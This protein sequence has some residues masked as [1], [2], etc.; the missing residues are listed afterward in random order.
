MRNPFMALTDWSVDRPKQAFAAV[1]LAMFTLAAGGMHLQ[2]DNSEDGFFPDDPRVDLLN[3]I[4]SEYR[5]NL[6]FIRFIDEIEGEALLEA[7]TWEQLAV[8]EAM[9]LND[10]NLEPYHYP[11]F[12]TQAN[13][14]PA[15]Q[16]MQ[17]M[18]LQDEDT[19]T[20]WLAGLQKA[21]VEVL[22]AN[23][24]ANLS[25]ALA[26]L[27]SA[28]EYVPKVEPVSPERLLSWNADEPAAWLARMDTGHNLSDELGMLTG[29]LSSMTQSE[30]GS[31]RQILAVTG[32]LRGQLGPIM[33]LQSIDFRAA[34]LSCLPSDDADDPW[35]SD[36]PVMVTWWCPA[37]PRLR[38]RHPRGCSGGLDGWAEAMEL[39]SCG[40]QRQRRA[41]VLVRSIRREQQRHHRQ[42]NRHVDQC[43]HAA[44]GH[45]LVVQLPQRSR[46]R[47]R[48][49]SDGGCNRRHLRPL[50][51]AA[52]RRREHDLQRRHEFHSRPP[53]GDWC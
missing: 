26:N 39:R 50:G 15:G 49:H 51:M 27:S 9:M 53:S 32:P 24:D 43:R 7:E 23:D 18:A 22:M 52:V 16:A 20:N 2:F 10:S 29:Q 14:G 19:A 41:H 34:I 38:L 44:I 1:M 5:A 30:P 48:A 11:L 37:S 40:H 28:A 13:N 45:H 4:E 21:A 35:V 47:L 8:I 46:D 31:N 36:G 25:S 12:G 42:G 33:G 17:W 3:E 6:D